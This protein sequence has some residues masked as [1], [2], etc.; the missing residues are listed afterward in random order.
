MAAG[1][2]LERE[3]DE[4]ERGYFQQPERQHGHR[5]GNKKLQQRRQHD[6]NREGRQSRA[7]GRADKIIA[8]AEN[9]HGQRQGGHGDEGDAPGK[10][11]AQ[12]VPQIINRLEQELADVALADVGGNLPVVLV[13]RRQH[14]HHG[15]QEIIENHLGRGVAG[16]RRPALLGIDGA[17]ERQHGEQRDEAEQRAR[18]VIDA[19]RQVVLDPDAD[20][21][22][23]F[24][25]S[26]R[27]RARNP[28]YCNRR[29]LTIS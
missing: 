3:Q 26:L 29:F 25:H 6:G 7:T 9:E 11:Q 8:E 20:D 14:V 23:V 27:G 13:H 19:V 22:P 5:V 16:E 28:V 4:D 10:K 21:M 18:Q 15:D 17:P 1:Q 12:P 2:V 24:F